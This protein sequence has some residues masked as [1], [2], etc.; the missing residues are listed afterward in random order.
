MQSA[1]QHLIFIFMEKSDMLFS[2]TANEYFYTYIVH[3]CKLSLKS[4][5]IIW[6][7]LLCLLLHGIYLDKLGLRIKYYFY[8]FK[9]NK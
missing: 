8:K 2:F 7:L 5:E 6:K 9:I 1:M 3:E 4:K